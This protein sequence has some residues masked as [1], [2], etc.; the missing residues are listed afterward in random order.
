MTS[1][2]CGIDWATDH[3][4]IALLDEAGTLLDK[5]RID[6]TPDGLSQLLQLL[7]QHGDGPEN[8]IPIGS[9]SAS[10][11]RGLGDAGRARPA[12]PRTGPPGVPEPPPG[13]ASPA[14]QA[15]AGR[16]CPMVCSVDH[17]ALA[18]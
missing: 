15:Q 6:D 4:D 13:L 11:E 16:S 18:R 1:V 12:R 9:G 17:T 3:R 5:L 7:A 2:F 8:P 10:E 14:E